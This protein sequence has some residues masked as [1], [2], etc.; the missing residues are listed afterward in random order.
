M[1]QKPSKFISDLC[2]YG[3]KRLDLSPLD[4]IYAQNQLLALFGCEEPSRPSDAL[5]ADLQKD[6]LD[7]LV[8]IGLSQ[9]LCREETRLSFETRLMGYVLPAPSSVAAS[10][11]AA[12]AIAGV[13]RA[14][15]QLYEQCVASNYIRMADIKKN[16]RWSAPG[17]RGDLTI[18]INLSK[19]EKDNKQV[20]LEK[21][22][23]Q[24][25]YPKC[26]LCL[27]NV[28]FPGGGS[29]TARQTL[30]VIPVPLYYEDWYF[31]FSHYVY[32]DHHCIVFSEEH[33][34]MSIDAS[35]FTKLLDFTVLFP[36][37]FIGSNSDLPIVGGSILS[38]EH[39][40]GGKR[41]LPM[42]N[43][44]ALEV[45]KQ[46]RY[47]DVEF[48]VL[49]WY[50]SVIRLQSSNRVQLEAYASFVLQAWRGYSDES[51]DIIANTGEQHN[52][53]TPIAVTARG[54]HTLYLILRNNRTDAGHPH[55]IFH[56]SEDLHNIKKEAIGLIEA[57]GIFILPGRLFEEAKA[58]TDILTGKTPLNFAAFADENHPLAKHFAMIIQLTNDYGVNLSP[59]KAEKAVVDYINA[60]CIRILECTAVF[61]NTENGKSA[62]RKFIKTVI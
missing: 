5:P 50:N 21:S 37:Y 44:P 61:K 28:G 15:T 52:T 59:A 36:H 54:A 1:P 13:K 47:G 14:T 8:K 56:P 46:K 32:Y 39:F 48:S 19:P 2:A 18:T 12:A 62:F 16:I 26:P 38:H 23:P 29:K 42:L 22:L 3:T 10:F 17:G 45:F 51:A 57:M 40:Q 33:R 60:A 49:D 53:V 58:M 20:A 43:R 4:A 7:P 30:R 41:V 34:P 55:G 9:G 35:T 25:N 27:T 6:I 24:T 31:Q 11:D